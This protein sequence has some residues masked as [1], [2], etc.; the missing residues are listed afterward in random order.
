MTMNGILTINRSILCKK[1]IDEISETI[2]QLDELLEIDKLPFKMT[3]AVMVEVAYVGQMMH[4]YESASKE[5]Y[6]RLG[7]L[8]CA[9]LVREAT[10][11]VG[12]IVYQYDLRKALAT[13]KNIINSLPY[14]KEK[15]RGVLY[16]FVDGSALNTRI[17]DN[18]GS[19]WRE[20]KL[21]L[22]YV[23]TNVIKRGTKEKNG[24]TI[25]KKEY[26][27]FVGSSVE[28]QKFVYQIAVNQ[29]YG[30]YETTIVIGD[31][32]SWIRTMCDEVFPDAIQIL[33]YYH[34]EENIYDFAKAIYTTEKA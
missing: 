31:G 12:N 28:F 26:T 19:T 3:K 29:G 23:S 15:L 18:D 2:V 6:R 4:S 17:K 20:N 7:Y 11:Y 34:L 1:N 22:S 16:I 8:V 5:L 13:Q 24:H 32:A 27:A 33:D 9:S 30:K 10:I 14:I 25:T 21:G